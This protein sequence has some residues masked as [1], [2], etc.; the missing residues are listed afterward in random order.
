MCK[1]RNLAGAVVAGGDLVAAGVLDVIQLAVGTEAGDRAVHLHPKERSS[2]RGH[3]YVRVP[4]GREILAGMAAVG[5]VA[6]L[7]AAVGGD[8]DGAIRK[9]AERR[10]PRNG[11]AAPEGAHLIAAIDRLA[12]RPAETE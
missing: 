1:A 7:V 6:E 3:Q 9:C 2:R 8:D 5:L 10:L 4:G 11:P 12:E